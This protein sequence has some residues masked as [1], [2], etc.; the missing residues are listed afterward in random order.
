MYSERYP[1]PVCLLFPGDEVNTVF[2]V[3]LGD[4]L[5]KVK[6]VKLR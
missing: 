6:A 4:V 5:S 2:S 1:M 3:F